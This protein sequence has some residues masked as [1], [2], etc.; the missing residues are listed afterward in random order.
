MCSVMKNRLLAPL[1]VFAVS[2][3]LATATASAAPVYC[4][5]VGVHPDG[6]AESDVTFEGSNSDDCYGVVDDNDS[7]ALINSLEGSGLWGGEWDVKVDDG[8]SA[9]SFLGFD[10]SLAADVGSVS[11]DWTLTLEDT[12]P[13]GGFVLPVTVDIIS[14]I[15]AGSEFAAYFF[16]DVTFT[17]L[18]DSDGTFTVT[19]ANNG[20]QFPALSHMS[21]YLREGDLPD[22][23]P[24]EHTPVPEPATMFMLGTGLVG[25]AASVRKRFR[26]T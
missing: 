10:W 21:L 23:P 7:L 25:V 24:D 14:V 12:P 18:G 3:T 5:A 15:K 9:V 1:G 8:G 13:P 4:S 6:I 22:E 20:G 17:L 11:G 19:F 2:L 16:D 26:R